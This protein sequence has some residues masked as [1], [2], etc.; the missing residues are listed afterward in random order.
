[1]LH[2]SRPC[3]KSTCHP[4]HQQAKCWETRICRNRS[5]SGHQISLWLQHRTEGSPKDVEIPDHC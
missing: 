2:R 3:G 1:V 4:P 5:G